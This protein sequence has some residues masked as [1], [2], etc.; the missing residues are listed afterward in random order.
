M[1]TASFRAGADGVRRIYAIYDTLFN[2]DGTD[3]TRGILT[4][5][6][7]GGT[8]LERLNLTREISHEHIRFELYP[9]STSST[10]MA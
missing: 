6:D 2:A 10:F 7:A 4:A 3:R 8:S 5:V 1:E 9:T